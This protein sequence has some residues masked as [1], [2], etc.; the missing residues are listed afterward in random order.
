MLSAMIQHKSK[1]E[2]LRQTDILPRH[3]CGFLQ[4][5]GLDKRLTEKKC[6]IQATLSDV[7]S[8]EL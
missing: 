5:I 2:F 4:V 7:M 6:E 8:D 1:R 3:E